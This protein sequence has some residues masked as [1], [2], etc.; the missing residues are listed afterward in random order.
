MAI[1]RVAID[2]V[3]VAERTRRFQTRSIKNASKLGAM[4]LAL[5]MVDLTTLEG[6]DTPGKAD[7]IGRERRSRGGRP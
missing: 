1:S 4:E 5:S 6:S 2:A 3:G 7:R